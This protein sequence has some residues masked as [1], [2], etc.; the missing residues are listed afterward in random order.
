MFLYV[1]MK[2]FVLHAEHF[3]FFP[4]TPCSAKVESASLSL[5]PKSMVYGLPVYSLPIYDLSPLLHNHNRSR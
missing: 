4:Y 2:R 5:C 1:V 3:P